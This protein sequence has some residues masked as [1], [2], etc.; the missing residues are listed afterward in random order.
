[1]PRP[2]AVRDDDST[3]TRAVRRS[4]AGWLACAVIMIGG[5]ARGPVSISGI[6]ALPESPL[7]ASEMLDPRGVEE[8]FGPR[9]S[10]SVVAA[11]PKSSRTAR[12]DE[13]GGGPREPSE[14]DRFYA[15]L[16]PIRVE[17]LE[18]DHVPGEPATRAARGVLH[19]RIEARK[20]MSARW[21]ALAGPSGKDQPP[22][23]FVLFPTLEAKMTISGTTEEAGP[24]RVHPELVP[25]FVDE[26]AR[27]EDLAHARAL[28]RALLRRPAPSD[29]PSERGWPRPNS[30]GLEWGLAVHLNGSWKGRPAGMLSARLAAAGVLPELSRIVSLPGENT[31]D[32]SPLILGPAAGSLV[33]FGV[34]HLGARAFLTAAQAGDLETALNRRL[35]RPPDGSPHAREQSGHEDAPEAPAS[36]DMVERSWWTMLPAPNPPTARPLPAE[37]EKG[38]SLAH[39]NTPAGGYGSDAIGATL[40]HLVALGVR[41]IS[42]TPFGFQRECGST[43]IGY[44]LGGLHAE[45]DESMR[46]VIRE[47]HAR[48][49]KVLYKPHMWVGH[50]AWCGEIA[51]TSETEWT[52]WFAAYR[53]FIVHHALLAEEERVDLL[54]VANELVKTAVRDYEWRHVIASVRSVYGGPLT[55][56]A[57]WGE[58]VHVVTFWDALDAVGV[59]A[60]DPLTDVT[61]ADDEALL[62]GA[63]ANAERI[64]AI[65]RR[66][67]KP[68]ILTEVGF[69][70]RPECWSQP[71]R[72]IDDAPAD[73]NCQAR[74]YKAVLRAFDRD[75]FRGLY[76]WKYESDPSYG[77]LDDNSFTPKGKPA[78]RL[79]R[80][81]YR[82][83]R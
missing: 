9:S 30:D 31:P 21:G 36:G 62:A 59:N 58:E 29:Q 51:M 76:W 26:D 71:H 41:W 24:A 2:P 3:P 49:L 22:V 75:P 79:I 33:D 63:R 64:A 8:A 27:L 34:S 70:S 68:V 55:Y 10:V 77:G 15:S 42:V 28:A 73:P 83:R 46:R 7:L 47:A 80:E 67:A 53:E 4:F 50:G 38:V 40:D 19:R 16:V 57:N 13:H 60:Y 82:R 72:E 56:A 66:A 81:A 1:M 65:G 32:I 44:V 6:S 20:R 17:G 39:T 45:T 37:F 25:L 61:Q 35:A 78:E 74:A 11:I 69:A 14:R 54:S 23:R 43:R 5:S 52:T 18:V 48:R 12:R